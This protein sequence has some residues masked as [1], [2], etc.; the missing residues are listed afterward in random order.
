MLPEAATPPA[1]P[2]AFAGLMLFRN[3]AFRLAVGCTALIQ[4]AHA[5]YY[6]FAALFWRSQGLSDTVIGLLI[7]E[8][9]VAEILLFARGRR[10]VERLGPAGLTACAAR[11]GVALVDHGVRAAAAGAGGGAT[12]S[13]RDI[14]HAASVGHAGP[15]PFCPD[16]AGGDGAGA[17]RGAG[18]WGADRV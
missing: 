3:P 14:R 18:L 11:L 5:A 15:E 10:L 13:R 8:G 12:G 6:G 16:R 4:G 1:A 7:A 17:A 9:I 2:R